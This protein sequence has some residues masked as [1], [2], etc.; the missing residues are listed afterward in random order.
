MIFIKYCIP[1]VVTYFS[2]ISY[3]T[4]V[5]VLFKLLIVI[6]FTACNGRVSDNK[7]VIRPESAK[8][9]E[10]LKLFINPVCILANVSNSTLILNTGATEKAFLN[11]VLIYGSDFLSFFSALKKNFPGK[12]ESLLV[13]TSIKCRAEHSDEKIHWLYKNTNINFQKKLKSISKISDSEFV[14]NYEANIDATICLKTITVSIEQD[15]CRILLPR[16]I[17]QFLK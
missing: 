15:T 1:K 11:P 4:H 10:D 2:I 14:L 8:V 7:P 16:N 13:F 3:M 5:K 6:F 12:P 17:N 9:K